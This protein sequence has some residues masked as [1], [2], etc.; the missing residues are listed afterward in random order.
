MTRDEALRAGERI[1]REGVLPSGKPLQA[2]V[3]GD[4]PVDGRMFSCVH[5]HL[6]SG[7]GAIEG[8]IVV[9]PITGP[10]LFKPLRRAAEKNVPT[11]DEVPPWLDG[12]ELRPAYSEE[13]LARAIRAGIDPAGRLLDDTMPRYRLDQ[14]EM[15]IVTFY[16]K[17]LS[18]QPSPG[19]DETTMRLATVVSE[20]VA[21]ED[22]EAMLATLEAHVRDRNAQSRRPEAR[23]QRGTFTMKDMY[24]AFRRVELLTW[25]LRGPRATWPGQLTE[26]LRRSPVF[27]LVGGIVSGDWGPVEEFAE[28]NHLPALMPVTDLPGSMEGQWYTLYVSKGLRGEGEAAARFL[29]ARVGPSVLPIQV[30]RDVPGSRAVG[31]GFRA[32][33][34]KLGRRA[35]LELR[36]GAAEPLRAEQL[37]ELRRA[38]PEAAILCWLGRDDMPAVAAAAP[39]DPGATIF[40]ASGLLGESPTLP[41]TLRSSVYLTYPW[42]LPSEAQKKRALVEG[43]LRVKKIPVIRPRIQ[44]Q[45]YLLGSL[46][47]EA[48]LQMR[49]NFYRDALLDAVDTMRDQS[50][51]VAFYPRLS[52]GPGQRYAAKGCYVVQEAEGPEVGLT[53]RSPW[54]IY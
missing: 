12:G 38:S 34:R 21:R 54:V 46:L 37:A 1:Y 17:N 35:P 33:W 40:V 41:E 22:R 5:C 26:H 36:L 24:A 39:A 47:F 44:A 50:Y 11:W 14:H 10:K 27:A 29:A 48:L 9:R 18:A 31:D 45:M 16:L 23:A 20:D 43:W 28:A 19:V 53:A 32:V 4:V 42:A 13:T 2:V 6:R 7:L 30:S 51:P 15:A 52:F 49:S 8:P 3:K 25:E